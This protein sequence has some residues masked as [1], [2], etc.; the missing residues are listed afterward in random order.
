MILLLVFKGLEMSED[1]D[2]GAWV[3]FSEVAVN[4]RLRN[5]MELFARRSPTHGPG[6]KEK[7][8]VSAPVCG[9]QGRDR[10][11]LELA[12]PAAGL[13]GLGLAAG[14]STSEDAAHDGEELKRA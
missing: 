13:G 14:A 9:T 8:A 6:S 1:E 4:M 5:S 7:G 12:A 2:C 11:G 3:Q 10:A